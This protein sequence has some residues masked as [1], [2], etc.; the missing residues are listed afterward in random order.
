VLHSPAGAIVGAA[1]EFERKRLAKE[2]ETVG[3]CSLGVVPAKYAASWIEPGLKK[4]GY[5]V[6]VVH[7]SGMGAGCL[8]RQD[9]RASLMQP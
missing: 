1:K 8:S 2:K 5:E 4:R 6:A 9:C 3:L 7:A